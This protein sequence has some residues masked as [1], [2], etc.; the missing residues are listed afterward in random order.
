MKIMKIK[1]AILEKD[2]SYLNRIVSAFSTK[3]SDKFEIY[4][5]TDEKIAIETLDSS[6]IDVLVASDA[7]EID[8]TAIPKRCGFAYFVDSP[9]VDTVNGQRAICKFQKADLI[10]KQILSIYSENSGSVFGIELGDNSTKVIFFSSPCGGT[11]TSTVAA[12]CA[13]HFA[14]QRKKTLYLNME[15]FG[16]SDS[17]FSSEGMFDMSDIIYALKSKKANLGMKLESCVK[18]DVSGVYFISQCK[19]ALDMNEL[20]TE[21]VLKLISELKLHGSYDYIVVDIDFSNININVSNIL[22]DVEVILENAT[23]KLVDGVGDKLISLLT[24]LVNIV[25][26]LFDLDLFYEADLNAYVNIGNASSSPYQSFMDALGSLFTAVDDFKAAMEEG[27]LFG[28]IKGAL[29]AMGDMFSAIGDL[30]GAIVD[31]AGAAVDSIVELGGSLVSGDVQGLYEKFL[32]SGYMRH[33][34][35]CRLD[36]GDYSYDAD[37]N[38]LNL[39]LTGKGL[40]GFEFN[41]IARPRPAV[42]TGQSVSLNSDSGSK[43]QGLASTLQNLKN[44]YGPDRMF[45]GA[46]LEYIRAGTNSEIANQVICFFD[47]YFLRLLLDLPFIFRDGEVNAVAGAATVASWVVY[48]LYIVAEPFCDTLLLVNGNTVPLIRNH[49][50]LTATGLGKFID[51]L[52]DVLGEALQNELNEYASSYATSSGGSSGE[53]DDGGLDYRTHMLIMLLIYVDC[54]SIYSYCYTQQKR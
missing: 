9:G 10:Y 45:K 23:S 17:F 42:Y 21:D 19:V 54:K 46:E 25:K 53:S 35:P 39:N 6:R 2:Q 11:G 4:S 48:I 37:G 27:G 13:V 8:V 1:L 15:M 28:K 20:N 33:N 41:K 26:K 3:Y 52:I 24:K 38:Q 30:M 51:K 47:L 36:S 32:I 22:D 34:L 43:F 14:A 50:W 31:I 40:T 44:G 12:A 49:C 18:Q 29:E 16:S 5:F 7:F